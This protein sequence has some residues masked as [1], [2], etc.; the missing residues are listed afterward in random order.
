LSGPSHVIPELT[1]LAEPPEF[2]K[3]NLQA[4]EAVNGDLMAAA[5]P[6]S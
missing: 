3:E 4:D 6:R 5:R 2:L 1:A